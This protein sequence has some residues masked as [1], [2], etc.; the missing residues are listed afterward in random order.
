M[1]EALG[2]DGADFAYHATDLYVVAKPG[3]LEWLEANHSYP[4]NISGF[5]SQED[6]NWN[7]AGKWCLDIPFAGNWP[8]LAQVYRCEFTGRKVGTQ[9]ITYP[10]ATEVRATSEEEA[11]TRLYDNFEHIHS[12]RIGQVNP[13]T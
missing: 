9:G 7:G 5:R 13:N 3:V 8:E 11:R 10:I 4:E 1:Q 12:L 2:L 6:S